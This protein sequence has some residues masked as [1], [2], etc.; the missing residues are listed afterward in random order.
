MSST[1][2]DFSEY[3]LTRKRRIEEGRRIDDI[4]ES[5]AFCCLCGYYENPLIIERH[6]IAGRINSDISI[7]VCPNCHRI[8]SNKQRSWP[9]DWISANNPTQIRT[10]LFLRGFDEMNRIK[11]NFFRQMLGTFQLGK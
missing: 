4:I 7:P 2:D 9:K 10:A 1:P 8:L 3:F 11:S 6:H 5:G